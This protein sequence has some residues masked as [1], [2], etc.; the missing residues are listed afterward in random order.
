LR[1]EIRGAVDGRLYFLFGNIDV[2]VQVELQGDD[3]AAERA[4]GGHLIQPGNFAELPF[5]RRGHR[6]GHHFGTAARVKGLNL[7]RRVV[8]LRQRRH[9]QLAIGDKADQQ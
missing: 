8:D 6:G 1:Q 9:R 7:D 3:R 5:E 4:D 2:E